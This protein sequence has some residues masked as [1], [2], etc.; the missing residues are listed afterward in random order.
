MGPGAAYNSAWRI[1][2]GEFIALLDGDDL[3]WPD[4]IKRQV[5]LLE[6]CPGVGL[7]GTQARLVTEEGKPFGVLEFPTSEF[8][9]R[10]KMWQGKFGPNSA[11]CGASVMMRNECVGKVGGWNEVYRFPQDA[12][13]IIRISENYPIANLPEVLYDYRIH[14]RQLSNMNIKKNAILSYSV[15]VAARF[16]RDNK[17][18]PHWCNKECSREEL[19]RIGE[20]LFELDCIEFG[21]FMHMAELWSLSMDWIHAADAAEAAFLLASN[22]GL[23]VKY[24]K[25]AL[26]VSLVA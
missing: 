21:S 19:E 7:V 24:R 4:K 18:V 22:R 8:D 5:D 14:G 12:D 15:K 26:G 17:P 16:R 10:K 25:K 20:S 13:I 1:A 23:G 9:I 11:F 6:N 3:Y 2:R